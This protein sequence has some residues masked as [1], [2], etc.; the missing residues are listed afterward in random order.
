M[1]RLQEEEELA[2]IEE[3]EVE[4]DCRHEHLSG[5]IDVAVAY[6]D[7]MPNVQGSDSTCV[8]PVFGLTSLLLANIVESPP[9]TDAHSDLVFSPEPKPAFLAKAKKKSKK[10]KKKKQL[11]FFGIQ[12]GDD[13]ETAE[14][15]QDVESTKRICN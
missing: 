13:E 14:P 1:A 5:D 3:D 15:V 7:E 6:D 12:T 2:E 4:N 10:K 11:D 9:M 8:M